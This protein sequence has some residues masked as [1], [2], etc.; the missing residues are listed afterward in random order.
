M[1]TDAQESWYSEETATFGD[2]LAGAREAAGLE[3]KELARHLGIKLKTLASWEDDLSDPRANKLQMLAGVLNVSLAWLLT[4]K[5]EGVAAP[6]EI[7]AQNPDMEK[8]L[9]EMRQ[10]KASMLR[11]AEQMARLEKTLRAL[12]REAGH[13]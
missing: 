7:G 8:V 1:N 11:G 5:G 2:R 9:V 13:E 6:D 3:R 10:L 12:I 4:G